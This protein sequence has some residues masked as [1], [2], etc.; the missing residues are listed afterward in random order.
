M[1]TTAC[2]PIAVT[3]PTGPASADEWARGDQTAALGHFEVIVKNS[4]T[5]ITKANKAF[6][7]HIPISKTAA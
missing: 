5:L 1:L 7:L 4:N 2:H 6:G 3:S